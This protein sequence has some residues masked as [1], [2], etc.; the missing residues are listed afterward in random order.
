MKKDHKQILLCAAKAA[1]IEGVFRVNGYRQTYG[2]NKHMDDDLWNPITNK[3]D[4][5][6]LCE[7]CGL[8]VDFEYGE[9]WY[10]DKDFQDFITFTPNDDESEALAILR[11]AVASKE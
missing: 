8:T 1:G 5:W 10:A 11:A 7:R 2:I 6:D 9:V 3:A 4:R